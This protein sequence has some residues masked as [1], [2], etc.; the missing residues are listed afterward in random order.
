MDV[1]LIDGEKMASLIFYRISRPCKRGKSSY[2]E[3]TLQLSKIF[4]DWPDEME[5]G[6]DENVKKAGVGA[7]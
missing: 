2:N 4:D 6:T 7:T 1:S 3:Q 5:V